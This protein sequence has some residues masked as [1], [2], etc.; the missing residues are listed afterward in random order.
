MS[1]IFDSHAHYDAE[2]FNEDREAV[3]TALP[4]QGVCAVVQCATDPDSIKKSLAMAQ[5]YPYIRVAVGIHPEFVGEATEKYFSTLT[6]YH[7]NRTSQ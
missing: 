2:Q 5:Q 1:L 6:L 3:L 4:T 7:K